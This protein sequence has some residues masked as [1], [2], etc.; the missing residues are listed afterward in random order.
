MILFSTSVDFNSLIKSINS[1]KE[2]VFSIKLTKKFVSKMQYI[3]SFKSASLALMTGKGVF[4]L[5]VGSNRGEKEW[6]QKERKKGLFN[7]RS[8]ECR[9]HFLIF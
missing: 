1:S 7:S 6:N 3:V 2:L 8:F 4:M 9:A 5:S